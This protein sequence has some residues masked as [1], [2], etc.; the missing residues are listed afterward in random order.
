MVTENLRRKAFNKPALIALRR[1]FY[2]PK[3]QAVNCAFSSTPTRPSSQCLAGAAL[4]N[5][6]TGM[7]CQGY[8]CEI[9]IPL[10]A[11]PQEKSLDNPKARNHLICCS[12]LCFR[13]HNL[14]HLK[15]CFSACS[16]HYRKALVKHRSGPSDQHINNSVS[17]YVDINTSEINVNNT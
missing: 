8:R 13:I 3:Y 1:K 5:K 6:G 10:I 9:R 15:R 16:I 17:K 2:L 14:S 11:K 7:A 12:L 4:G